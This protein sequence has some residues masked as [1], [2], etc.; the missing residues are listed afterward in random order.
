MSF[1][2]SRRLTPL[3]VLHIM[4]LVPLS[5]QFTYFSHQVEGIRWMLKKEREGTWIPLRDG[6]TEVCVRGGMQCDEMGLGKTIQMTGVMVNHRVPD[7]L[8]LAPLAML[9]TWGSVCQSSGLVVYELVLGSRDAAEWIKRRGSPESGSAVYITNFEKL[10]SRPRIFSRKWDR[11]VMD[12]AHKIRNPRSKIATQC[13]RL[14]A[15]FRWVLTGTPLVNSFQDIVSLLAF[16]GVPYLSNWKWEDRYEIILPHLLIHRTL[17]SIRNC[18]HDAP[19]VPIIKEVELPFTT[20]AEERFYHG[21]QGLSSN[22]KRYAKELL[23]SAE[24]FKQ[25][26][27]L[28]QLS[29]HPQIFID[30]KRREDSR[31]DR[32]DWD[33][34]S[35][36]LEAVTDILESERHHKTAHKY[37][38]FCQFAMEMELLREH[39]VESGLVE[40]DHILEYDG[41]KTQA[42]RTAVLKRSKKLKGT[43]VL[44]LQIQAGGVGLNLQEYDRIIFLSPW[45]TASLRDQ[46]I[47]RAVRMGQTKTVHV[48]H[49]LLSAEK[50]NSIN[51]DRIV[52]EKAEE[53]Q[54]MLSYLFDICEKNKNVS[55]DEILEEPLQG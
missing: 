22:K 36:K 6:K 45:W 31:Y 26:I 18:V 3:H 34:P 44:L 8:L 30:A 43:T 47:A 14:K 4:P 53:K 29:I 51:I 23:N 37:I 48:W 33:G 55:M 13:R 11:V 16:L 10:T 39:L 17:D 19:P 7:T 9:D 15:S 27:R 21:V 40:D 52:S 20:K 41:S 42:E 38:L 25:L 35:T 1:F 54:T 46:A 24:K 49:L 5:D 12:E 28:R 50:E 2:W 32:E